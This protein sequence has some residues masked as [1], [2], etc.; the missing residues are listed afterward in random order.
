MTRIIADRY[1]VL[2][3]PVREGGLADVLACSDLED[4]GN[5]VAVKLLKELPDG[6]ETLQLLFRREVAALRELRH[7]NIVLLR[8]AGTDGVSGRYFLTLEWVAHDL[9][10]WMGSRPA[11]PAD[12]FLDLIALPLLRALAFAHERKVIHRDL[13]PSN[14]LVTSD[15]VP[16][17]ADFGISKIKTSLSEGIHTLAAYSSR[18]FAPPESES[19]SSFSRDVFAFG[20][21]LLACLTKEPIEDYDD[22]PGALD[23]LEADLE[24][25]DLIESCTSLNAADRPRSGPEL[26]LRVEAYQRRRRSDER[27]TRLISLELTGSVRRRVM[28]EEKLPESAVPDL[29][30]REIADS[31][32]LRPLLEDKESPSHFDGPWLG[33]QRHFYI[34]GDEWSFRLVASEESPRLKVIS[35]VRIGAINNDLLRDRHL[36]LAD[37]RFSLDPPLNYAAARDDI[38]VVVEEGRGPPVVATGRSW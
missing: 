19:K 24:L 29:I 20:V 17:L 5:R 10:S 25:V 15:G 4:G 26:L 32:S 30:L 34:Y 23:V 18:P 11:P 35:A 37:V 28:E 12:T 36:V 22:F 7:E 9:V 1:A 13:K 2:S 14:V 31:P 38:R 3:E 33:E 21:L 6:D 16:K 8:D 27:R